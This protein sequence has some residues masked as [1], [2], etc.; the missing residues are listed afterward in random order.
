MFQL[1]SLSLLQGCE[2]PDTNV[3][4]TI[5]DNFPCATDQVLTADGTCETLPEEDTADTGD[6]DD[7]GDTG[8]TDEPNPCS[9]WLPDNQWNFVE[10]PT[11]PYFAESDLSPR[12]SQA[13][14]WTDVFHMYVIADE[15][16][17]V[18]MQN[19]VIHLY[20][21]DVTDSDWGYR[22]VDEGRVGIQMSYG[23]GMVDAVISNYVIYDEN[24]IAGD[25]QIVMWVYVPEIHIY[26]GW[27]Y[28]FLISVDTTDGAPG[29]WIQAVAWSFVD[30][31]G[32]GP[33]ELYP[34]G[35]TFL[36]DYPFG[37]WGSAIVLE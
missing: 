2:M 11:R 24:V 15:C 1:L 31:F 30:W 29:D 13:R 3:E 8:D 18:W 5:E 16:G 32:T 33:S 22:L 23:D 26:A 14:G 20:L 6:S 17:D 9:F 25:M 4:V 34:V 37:V 10:L 7:T 28:P 35:G 19:F 12:G 36:N 21:T 27:G